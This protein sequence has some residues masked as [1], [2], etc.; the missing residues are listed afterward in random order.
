MPRVNPIDPTK[1]AAYRE[2]YLMPLRPS[3]YGPARQTDMPE[4]VDV[5][6]L[7][8]EALAGSEL[9]KELQCMN[10]CRVLRSEAPWPLHRQTLT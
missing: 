1:L 6:Q 2:R 4:P 3:H 8:R 5:Q 10:S 9:M 7:E